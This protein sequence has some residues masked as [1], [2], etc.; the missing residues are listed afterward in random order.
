MT[1]TVHTDAAQVAHDD[2]ADHD[3]HGLS[4][5]GY[6]KV[7]IFL[8]AITAIEVA[9]SY[10]VDDLG[11]LF[12]PLLLGLMLLKFFMVVLY[13]MHLKFDNKLFSLLFYIGLGLAVGVY[14]AA[15]FTFRFFS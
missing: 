12:L 9:L 14:L 10:M 7:A 6:V 13:F 3:D 15:L 2:H 4:D 11:A 8:A 5:L 1:D